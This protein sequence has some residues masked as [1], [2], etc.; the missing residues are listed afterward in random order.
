M[1]GAEKTITVDKPYLR[2]SIY[3]PNAEIVKGYPVG[4]M[5]AYKDQISEEDVE[6]IILYIKSISDAGKTE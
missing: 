1:D 5:P 2:K 3:E 4:I 6:K